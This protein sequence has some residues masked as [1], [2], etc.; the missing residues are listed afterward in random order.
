MGKI[1]QDSNGVI[2]LGLTS[3]DYGQQSIA[4]VDKNYIDS[5]ES[6]T[7]KSKSNIKKLDSDNSDPF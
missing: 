6:I 2:D 4:F 3:N 1:R 7:L 5:S